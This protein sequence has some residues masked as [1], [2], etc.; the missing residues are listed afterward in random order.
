MELSPGLSTGMRSQLTDRVPTHKA[1]TGLVDKSFDSPFK[2]L[3]AFF[4]TESKSLQAEVYEENNGR[5]AR[6]LKTR[7]G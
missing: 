7:M 2:A 5:F 3:L 6:P 4:F 1:D